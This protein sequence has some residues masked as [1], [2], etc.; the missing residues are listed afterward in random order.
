MR[1]P[2]A[3]AEGWAE[4]HLVNARMPELKESLRAATASHTLAFCFAH[5]DARAHV[6]SAS[7]FNGSPTVANMIE[8][9]HWFGVFGT[10]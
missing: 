7:L 5:T 8:A 6:V 2:E 10:Y 3:E 9:S 1:R 4:Q